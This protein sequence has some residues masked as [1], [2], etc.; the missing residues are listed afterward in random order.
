V[1]VRSARTAKSV[2]QSD[3]ARQVRH[4]RR[5]RGLTQEDLSAL[6]GVAK[7]DISRFET[8]RSA[9]TTRTVDRIA[10]ALNA[11]VVLLP[12]EDAPPSVGLI[13]GGGANTD[14]TT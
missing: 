13:A 8:G 2:E 10:A 11:R 5:L 12:R 1:A 7:S 9:P 14:P 6:T 4:L 3:I